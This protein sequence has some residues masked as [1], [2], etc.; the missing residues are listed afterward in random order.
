MN[1]TE[2]DP[3]ARSSKKAAH[4]RAST[5]TDYTFLTTT[6]PTSDRPRRRKIWFKTK[7]NGRTP[8]KSKEGTQWCSPPTSLGLTR[9]LLP[10]IS[11]LNTI[12]PETT[13]EPLLHQQITTSKEW[14][15]R[16]ISP[17]LRS[18]LA[19]ST[20]SPGPRPTERQ[21]L[22][23]KCKGRTRSSIEASQETQMKD[24]SQQAEGWRSSTLSVKCL[25]QLISTD[26]G[27]MGLLW[28]FSIRLTTTRT[29]E[30][31]STTPWECSKIYLK[32]AQKP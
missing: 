18:K 21:Q 7:S 12:S 11:T 26:K 32:R 19:P 31:A 20:L 2:E 24:L 15:E 22:K 23:M 13:T 14:L 17:K 4:P 3:E 9:W 10:V 29:Q 30:F 28:C 1:R 27:W 6:R 5:R 16:P 25:K 8:D